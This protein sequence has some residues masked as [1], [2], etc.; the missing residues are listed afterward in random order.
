MTG[1]AKYFADV[2]WVVK[3]FAD[4]TAFSFDDVSTMGHQIF[5]DNVTANRPN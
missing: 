5:F 3:I 1:L 2:T 4:V